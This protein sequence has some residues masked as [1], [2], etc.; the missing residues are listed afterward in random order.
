MI[1]K[2]ITHIYVQVLCE[3]YFSFILGNYLRGSAVGELRLLHI[4][5][6]M[7]Y[8]QTLKHVLR[9]FSHL[10]RCDWVLTCDFN[11]YFPDD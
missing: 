11:L 3:H 2:A 1:N 7:W 4:F 6:S 8:C 9:N 10:N 5:P